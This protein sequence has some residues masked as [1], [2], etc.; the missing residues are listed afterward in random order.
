MHLL[1]LS[2]QKRRSRIF[3]FI[4]CKNKARRHSRAFIWPATPWWGD[5]R[6]WLLAG[7]VQIA[8]GAGT[9]RGCTCSCA[10]HCPGNRCGEPWRGAG[11]R[12]TCKHQ[13]ISLTLNVSAGVRFSCGMADSQQI[14][15]NGSTERISSVLV[16]G[17]GGC[18]LSPPMWSLSEKLCD[19][20]QDLHKVIFMSH[21]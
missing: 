11:R 13:R 7:T 19:L 1:K 8:S 12:H 16:C 2:W 21:F 10:P 9:S 17:S 20:R 6:H 14:S 15:P 18:L 4:A 3:G 5:N